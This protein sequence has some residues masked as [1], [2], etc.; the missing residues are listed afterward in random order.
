MT[1]A[2]VDAIKAEISTLRTSIKKICFAVAD[3]GGKEETPKEGGAA[4]SASPSA[5]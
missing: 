1:K 4:V 3:S 2:E 5:A